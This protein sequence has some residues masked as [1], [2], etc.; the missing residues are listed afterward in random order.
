ME[1]HIPVLLQEM[2][3]YLSPKDG[4]TYI[5]ATFGAGGY[6]KAILNHAN[7]F[8]YAL[9]RD[10]DVK[11]YAEPLI[12]K[13]SSRFKFVH[14]EFGELNQAI[15]NIP[16]N[17]LDGIVFDV[18]VSSMQL[19]TGH[20]GFSF[21]HEG[22][23]DMRMNTDNQLTAYDV[24][25]RYTEQELSHIIFT[26]GGERKSRKIAN[27]IVNARQ[28]SPI[29][30]TKAL[31]DIIVQSVGR[32]HDSIHPATRTFQAI[33]IIVNDEMGQLTRGIDLALNL[34]RV[35]GK[36]VVVTFHSLEDGIVKDIFVKA[37]GKRVHE[38]KYRQFQEPEDVGNKKFALVVKGVVHP[39]QNEVKA[40]PR[41][42]SAK[43]RAIQRVS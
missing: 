23:L 15:P 11:I 29:E 22:K 6:S 25:N 24:V 39:T 36:V 27:Y 13:Y 37:C 16:D 30:T 8:V 33:R 18:G 4:M 10:S 2:L 3:Q 7:C 20:R 9:D 31:S 14:G 12:L 17:N 43:L 41:A 1:S 40:N 32:Y 21:T 28:S 26:Y 34:V 5:D 35:G 38:N 42:R 19:S